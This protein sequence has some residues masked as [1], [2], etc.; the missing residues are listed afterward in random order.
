MTSDILLK[1]YKSSLCKVVTAGII[2]TNVPYLSTVLAQATV[3][4]YV[5]Q[6]E[7]IQHNFTFMH[8][9]AVEK[10]LILS[11]KTVHAF[12]NRAETLLSNIMPIASGWA[13][14]AVT[15]ILKNNRLDE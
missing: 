6:R 11:P 2:Y 4:K 5:F 12:M 15:N 14:T 10:V 1:T 13:R 3:C 9:N 8:I 7:R